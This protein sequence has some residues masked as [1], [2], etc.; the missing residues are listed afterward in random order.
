[1]YI[2]I[3]DKGKGERMLTEIQLQRRAKKMPFVLKNRFNHLPD[4]IKSLEEV[5]VA[6]SGKPFTRED[7]VEL[8]QYFQIPDEQGMEH[9]VFN[10]EVLANIYNLNHLLTYNTV[11]VIE[12]FYSIFGVD[13]PIMDWSARQTSSPRFKAEEARLRRAIR[14]EE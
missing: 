6:H 14:G 13:A 9:F 4:I 1:M 10:A 3:N 2:S 11:R 8:Y 7:W 5:R 12:S